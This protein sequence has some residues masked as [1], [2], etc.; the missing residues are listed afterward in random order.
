MNGT[1]A[2]KYLLLALS[3]FTNFTQYVTNNLANILHYGKHTEFHLLEY[4]KT[5]LVTQVSHNQIY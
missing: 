3:R 4:A 2:P 1:V 5:C